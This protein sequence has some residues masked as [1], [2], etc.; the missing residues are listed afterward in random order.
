LADQL[1]ERYADIE[2]ELI[3]G[4]GGAFEVCRDGELIF[5]KDRL[6]R[7]PDDEE[8]FAALDE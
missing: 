1:R 5:S 6:G 8:I 4:S 2:V 7:F 3:K